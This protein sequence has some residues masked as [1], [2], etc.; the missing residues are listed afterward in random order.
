MGDITRIYRRT[1]TVGRHCG[2]LEWDQCPARFNFALIRIITTIGIKAYRTTGPACHSNARKGWII[3]LRLFV[4]YRPYLSSTIYS[5]LCL[6]L[7]LLDGFPFHLI[8]LMHLPSCLDLLSDWATSKS[9][10]QVL[11]HDRK[12]LRY[13]WHLHGGL[14]VCVNF[15]ILF[16]I[17]TK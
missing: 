6:L 1:W 14:N 5:Q 11:P 4:A 2:K 15:G 16:R 17:N 8:R 7:S 12:V 9:L 10:H 3:Q 13:L